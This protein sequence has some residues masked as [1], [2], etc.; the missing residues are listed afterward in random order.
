MGACQLGGDVFAWVQKVNG[1]SFRHAY[2]LLT[3]G[4]PTPAS[5]APIK[6]TTVPKLGSPLSTSMTDEELMLAYVDYCHEE[7]PRKPEARAYL[8]KRGADVQEAIDTFRIGYANRTI[9]LRM[10]HSDRREGEE[11]R[12]RLQKL[13]I[14]RESGH[15]HFAG[16]IVVPIFDADGNVAEMY[17]RKIT[18]NLRAG[19][20]LH[21]YLPGPHRG[22]WN[23]AALR[24]SKELI[25]CEA[26]FD[27]LAFWC[28]GFR[29]VTWTYGV[30]GFTAEHLAA[31][32]AYA[33]EKVFIAYDADDAGN[34]AAER[35]ALQLTTAGIDAYRVDFPKGMDAS[36]YAAKMTPAAKALGVAV[37]A[38]RWLGNGD[39]HASNT[40]AE[41]TP[42]LAAEPL[43]GAATS[44]ETSIAAVVADEHLY[45]F[46][47]RTYA[48]RGMKKVTSFDSLKINVL[49]TRASI[50]A[51]H[52]DSFDLS[53]ARQRT[54]FE[55]HA[56]SEIGVA[57]EVVHRDMGRILLALE[58]VRR[59]QMLEASAPKQTRIAMSDADQANALEHLRAP[60]LIR[61]TVEHV[62]RCGIVGEDNNKLMAYLAAVSRKLDEPLAIII[63]SSS[64]AGKTTLMDAILRMMPDEEQERYSAVTG[65][66]L[67]YIG[68]E[69][70]LKH[71]ILA[72]S[73]EEGAEQATYA[74]KLLQ[75]EGKLSIASTGKDPQTGKLVT[76]EYHVEGPVMI[77]LTTT[78]I[79]IDEELM[80]RCIVLTVNEDREQTRAIHELQRRAQTLEGLVA[81]REANELRKLHQ[82]AQRLLQP[83]LVANPFATELTFL[84]ARTRTR[85][86]H[87]KYLTLI[88]AIALLHQ[89]QRPR[90]THALPAGGT[91]DYIEVERSD[92]A[93][94]N[95]LSHEVLGRSLDELPPQTRR[96]IELIDQYVTRECKR[97]QIERS[98]LRF[99]RRT[100]R[101][102]TGWSET[103]IRIHLDR[104]VMFEY[105]LVHRGGRGQ[106]FVY[107]LVYERS[108]V[109][110]S[111][112]LFG[113]AEAATL[114]EGRGTTSTSRGAKATSRGEPRSL[115]APSRGKSGAVA[116]ESRSA[117]MPREVSPGATFI[118]VEP[119][120]ASET[121]L[122]RT[123]DE[124]HVVPALA[125]P[126]PA[127]K[128]GNGRDAARSFRRLRRVP[129]EER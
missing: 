24:E 37:R 116:G 124:N 120:T 17:G 56:A 53:V 72:I 35:L 30:E 114:G 2:E 66:A 70:S 43:P 40:T 5:G 107:E 88:R 121:L 78:A 110:T 77:F 100:I 23:L 97:R 42:S 39:K 95:E 9:G 16:S 105:L 91:I 127:A 74:L 18:P 99:S 31:L 118:D 33:T 96:L 69:T 68:D 80:N 13:G 81:K 14:Y 36:E 119:E 12:S 11:L 129:R 123:E 6:R 48:I 94:A 64:A 34:R 92:I 113:L 44:A 19:T 26:A 38:A 79:D 8:A 83:I 1:V 112:R 57:E 117:S 86:D 28:A 22:V 101:E 126:K 75:S 89:Y 62:T 54:A 67:F 50:G 21:L 102:V 10:P 51:A 29:N 52:L 76:Q 61:R 104:L 59:Q 58:D 115:A 122:L 87:M 109:A 46:G 25:V 98:E 108:G 103:Q 60:D 82:N 55:K 27:A 47:D 41:P 4:T 93:L 49:L 7:L 125:F 15:E 3:G 71:K 63:Q 128:G 90:K 85:R 73:E 65:K 45:E 20:P 32:K 111:S 84:D 106:S